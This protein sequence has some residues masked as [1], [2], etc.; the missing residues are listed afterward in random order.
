VAARA[1]A[2]HPVRPRERQEGW[3]GGAAAPTAWVKERPTM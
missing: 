2:L 3:A 1:A